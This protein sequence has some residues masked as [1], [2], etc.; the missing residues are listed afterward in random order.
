M[1]D[2]IVSAPLACNTHMANGEYESA[3]ELPSQRYLNV[4]GLYSWICA[5]KREEAELKKLYDEEMNK[6]LLYAPS[7]VRRCLY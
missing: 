1:D 3:E 2:F 4:H 5:R 6:C 7:V